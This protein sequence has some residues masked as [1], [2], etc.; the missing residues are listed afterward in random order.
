MS[1]LNEIWL[2]IKPNLMNFNKVQPTP[3]PEEIRQISRNLTS[4]DLQF[5]ED[6]MSDI[7]FA[8]SIMLIITYMIITFGG[9]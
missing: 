2:A 1:I 7:P 8:F 3:S 6:F 4:Q 5:R 9:I